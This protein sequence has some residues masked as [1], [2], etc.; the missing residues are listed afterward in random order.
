MKHNLKNK[1]L[2]KVSYNLKIDFLHVKHHGGDGFQ[3]YR[4]ICS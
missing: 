1:K 2:M 4:A 3:D